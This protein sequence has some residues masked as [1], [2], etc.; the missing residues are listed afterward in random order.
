MLTTNSVIVPMGS[1]PTFWKFMYRVSPLTYLVDGLLSTGLAHNAVQCSPLELLQFSPPANV[2]CGAY[3]ETYMQVA[4][5][6]VY[7]PES[8]D[9]CQF[10]S[11]ADTDMFLAMTSASYDERWRNYGL[12]FVYIVFNLFAA[13]GLYWLARVPKKF[14]LSQLWKKKTA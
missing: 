11:L 1:L 7:N 9:T 4:G 6:R 2:T 8:T 13:L 10:C 3:M 5:G 12:M 14:S